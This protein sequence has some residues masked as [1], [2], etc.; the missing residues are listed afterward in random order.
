[1]GVEFS[2]EK[3]YETIESPLTMNAHAKLTVKLTQQLYIV[4]LHLFCTFF[5]ANRTQTW[6]TSTC[7]SPHYVCDVIS[8]E[9][10][11]LS[12]KCHVWK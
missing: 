5:F 12:S 11:D 10:R 7:R 4:L 6:R 3:R 1:M 9:S 2:E 8:L